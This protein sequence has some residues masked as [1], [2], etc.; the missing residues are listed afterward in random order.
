[1]N[2]IVRE[3]ISLIVALFTILFTLQV[4]FIIERTINIYETTLKNNYS[5]ITVSNTALNIDIV[6]DEIK[7][8]DKMEPIDPQKVVKRLQDELNKE[9]IGVLEDNLPHFYRVFLKSYPTPNELLKIK[10]EL[11]AFNGITRVET[12]SKTHDQIFKL[13][14]LFKDISNVFLLA[15]FLVSALLV[16]KEMRIWQFEH[17]ERMHIMALFGAPIWMRSAVLFKVAILDAFVSSILVVL[18][19]ITL[20][21]NGWLHELFTMI[22]IDVDIF[23]F[24]QDTFKLLSISIIISIILALV[25]ILKNRES[26]GK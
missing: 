16:V 14:I 12:Y 21:V 23:E 26:Y 5:M 25:T 8:I 3:H 17:T 2:L 15:I 1:M 11:E 9:D 4:Y 19:F 7:V 24:F 22:S 13:L 20:E 18:T 6:R 10:K